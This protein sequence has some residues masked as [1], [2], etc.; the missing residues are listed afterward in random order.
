MRMQTYS[1]DTVHSYQQIMWWLDSVKEYNKF[2]ELPNSRENPRGANNFWRLYK[3][4]A[5]NL[6]AQND[7]NYNFGEGKVWK[8][9]TTGIWRFY[10]NK[11]KQE[12]A[13]LRARDAEIEARLNE[14]DAEMEEIVEDAEGLLVEDVNEEIAQEE[15][16]KSANEA[17]DELQRILE[18]VKSRMEGN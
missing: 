13:Q 11:E 12:E 6:D 3:K 14:M 10:F 9:P 5:R 8:H 16:I 1:K 17:A 7:F 18:Q 4:E 2:V 15:A